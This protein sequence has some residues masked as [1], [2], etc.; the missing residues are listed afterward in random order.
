MAGNHGGRPKKHAVYSHVTES[1]CNHKKRKIFACNDCFS[2]IAQNT[3]RMVSHIISSVNAPKE[4]QNQF[5]NARTAERD[6]E[7]QES[8]AVRNTLTTPNISVH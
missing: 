7:V 2:D 3:G 8:L 5:T 6:E 1:A 4:V